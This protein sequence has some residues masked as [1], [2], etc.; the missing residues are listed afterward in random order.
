MQRPL[1]NSSLSFTQRRLKQLPIP[2]RGRVEYQDE[3]C[4]GL[5]LRITSKGV[6]TFCLL[7]RVNGQLVRLTIG[8]FPKM[9]V[10]QARDA[11][12]EKLDQIRRGEDPRHARQKARSMP[13]LG[14]LFGE[15][16][17]RH[18]KPHKRTWPEDQAQYDRYLQSWA[19]RKID[20]IKRG[21]VQTLHTTIGRDHG[22]YAANR[23]RAMLHTMFKMAVDAEWIDRNPVDGVKKFREEKRDRFLSA[24]ELRRFFLALEGTTNPTVKDCI[25]FALL[26]GAR[27]SNCMKMAWADLDC[28][29]ATWTI[30]AAQTKTAT[31]YVLPLSSVATDLLLR[32]HGDRDPQCPW[33]F[34]SPRQSGAGHLTTIQGAWEKIVKDAEL[35]G[36]RFHDLRRTLASWQALA[37]VPLLNIGRSL[38]HSDP[39]TTAIYARLQ[40]DP[41]RDGIELATAKML[42]HRP[43][44][45]Q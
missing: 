32:R 1:T 4:P 43:K 27:R 37:G 23:L 18:A 12:V 45:G 3:K 39:S 35:P 29:R 13:T 17:E 5:R 2:E 14:E 41:I 10:T 11:V 9:H 38:G 24:E 25:L 20:T 21:D 15:Y 34:P 19:G 42:E 8:P 6:K 7:K 40:N 44:N 22:I 16:M 26:T 36:V 33:V 28:G 31:P 30:P